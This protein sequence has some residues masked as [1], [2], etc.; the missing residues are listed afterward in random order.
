MCRVWSRAPDFEVSDRFEARGAHQLRQLGNRVGVWPTPCCDAD[1][2]R[3]FRS[4]RRFAFDLEDSQ[5]SDSAV[6]L[7]GRAGTTVEMACL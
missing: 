5:E 6:R 7:T 4:A 1:Q 2:Q 3:A